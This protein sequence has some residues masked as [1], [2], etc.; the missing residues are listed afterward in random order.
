LANLELD[1][2][3]PKARGTVEL[4]LGRHSALL[5]GN[6][7]AGLVSVVAEMQTQD[8]VVRDRQHKTNQRWLLLIA[9][10]PVLIK[11]LELLHWLPQ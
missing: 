10:I 2:D 3:W 7:K 1:D 5:D 11:V 4:M 8:T 6:G 9:A